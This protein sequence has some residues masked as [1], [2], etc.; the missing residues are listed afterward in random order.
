[1]KDRDGPK[2]PPPARADA[3][4]PLTLS[5]PFPFASLPVKCVKV[6]KKNDTTQKTRTRPPV[7]AARAPKSHRDG[8][9]AAHPPHYCESPLPGLAIACR[10]AFGPASRLGAKER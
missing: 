4:L 2:E 3:R 1:M 5:F 7:A 10:P 6:T 9:T 8:P